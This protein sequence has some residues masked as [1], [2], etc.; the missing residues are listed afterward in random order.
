MMLALAR[1][2][3]EAVAATRK[4]EWPRYNGLSLQG[5]TAGIVGLGA[6]GKQ[7]ARRLAAF[8]TRL[9]AYDPYPDTRFAGQYCIGMLPLDEVLAQSDFVSLHLPLLPETRGLVDDAFLGKMK[10][11]A[12]LINTAR[13]EVIDE[14]ALLRALKGG[15]LR[16]AALDA[17]SQE[18]PDP[19]NPLMT[20]PQV[21][22]T[23]H[24]GAHADSATNTMGQMALEDCLAVL[25][26]ENP[27]FRVA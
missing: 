11:G 13:G 21:L 14:A 8:D 23:P 3:P 4:G 12:F 26:G 18:P 17:F 15:R 10:P 24:M 7:L 5:K 27:R 22:V 1:H 25:R 16:G 6:I 19:A 20:L 9:L 2:I